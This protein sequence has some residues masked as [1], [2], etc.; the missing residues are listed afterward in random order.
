MEKLPLNA[1]EINSLIS[2]IGETFDQKDVKKAIKK[3][4]FK[5][6]QKGIQVPEKE[7]TTHSQLTLKGYKD[8]DAEAYIGPIDGTGTRGVLILI[9]HGPLGIDTGIG[10]INFDQGI[11]QFIYDR[12]SKKRLKEVKELF[13][14]QVGQPVE[15]SLS[16]AGTI[17]EKAF[18]H[19]KEK[20][21]DAANSY[22]KIRPLIFEHCALLDGPM[23]YEIVKPASE[24]DEILTDSLID[25]LLGHEL[26]QSWLIEPERI[27]FI[28]DEISKIESSPIIVSDV[29]KANRVREIKEKAISE[30]F[31]DS[32]RI[33]LK[34]D[35][36]EMA[37]FFF[38][39]DETDYVRLCLLAANAMTEKTSL[40]RANSFLTNYLE[41]SL[42]YYY[43]M[44]ERMEDKRESEEESSPL[45]ITP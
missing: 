37:F 45:I 7:G 3:V 18:T 24:D 9:P 31:P 27:G 23:I 5:L 41:R 16:H 19:N 33:R 38:K 26:M 43:D 17:L 28:I 35:L 11:L 6:R 8:I 34:D 39:L 14:N 36:E 42:N 25:K 12:F 32:V 44:M 15:T 21:G 13:S 30:L 22:L 1:P 10:I 4:L 29:Q 20:A 40:I 2:A